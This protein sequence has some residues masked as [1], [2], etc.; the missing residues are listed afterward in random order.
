MAQTK[1]ETALERQVREEQEQHEHTLAAMGQ[2]EDAGVLANDLI[3]AV[4]D[5][6]NDDD[7]EPI[8]DTATGQTAIIDHSQYEREDL[9]IPK[10]DGQSIDRISIKFAGEIFLD[11]SEPSDVAVYNALRLGK[12]VA[13]LV[14]AKC[15]STAAKGATDRDG[16]LDVVV[17]TKGLKVHTL[18]KPAGADWVE[19]V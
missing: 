3:T 16:D 12:D 15:S 11:R 8:V 7:P 2:A 6:E 14:E 4:D 9:Q 17:G 5:P 13:L 18:S 1:T 19:T 10:I